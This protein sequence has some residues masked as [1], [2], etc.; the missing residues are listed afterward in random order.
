MCMQTSYIV[1]VRPFIYMC[2]VCV[3]YEGLLLLCVCVCVCV[4]VVCV[5]AC[6][7]V[8][9]SE[10]NALKFKRRNMNY[11]FLKPDRSNTASI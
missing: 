6:V 2:V 8:C 1:T 3:L 4:C 10:S 5:R 11:S 9:V 7:H